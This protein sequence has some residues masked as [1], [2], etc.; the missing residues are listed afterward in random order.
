MP[1]AYVAS[2]PPTSW[3]EKAGSEWR[4]RTNKALILSGICRLHL[5]R[6]NSELHIRL[7]DKDLGPDDRLGEVIAPL[8]EELFDGTAR[9]FHITGA[10]KASGIVTV[11]LYSA[12][13]AFQAALTDMSAV[14]NGTHRTWS[15]DNV[16]GFM[17]FLLF[18]SAL[19]SLFWKGVAVISE[20][21]ELPR[22][23]E[24]STRV[25]LDY[26][27]D[28]LSLTTRPQNEA[29]YANSE[30]GGRTAAFPGKG[31]T[32]YLT[33]KDVSEKLKVV[34]KEQREGKIWRG[35]DLGNIRLNKVLYSDI[36]NSSI[37]L[38]VSPQDH[39]WIRPIVDEML[40][41]RGNWSVKGIRDSVR[42]FLASRRQLGNL[43]VQAHIKEWVATYLHRV[44]LHIEL[45]KEEAA[46]FVKIQ[47][48]ALKIV[49][50][51]QLVA[52]NWIVGKFLGVPAIL[53]W[54]KEWLEKYKLALEPKYP[55]LPERDLHLLASF[56]MDSL[57]FAG[58]LSVP[59]CISCA[60]GVVYSLHSPNSDIVLEHELIPSL[61]METLR[62][63]PP[64]V[65]FPYYDSPLQK[66]R[67]LLQLSC[68]ARDPAVWGENAN[69]FVLRPLSVYHKL[70]VSWA[71]GAVDGSMT[72]ACPARELSIK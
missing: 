55:D 24:G 7:L 71:D 30:D 61:I 14:R 52:N 20:W 67:T 39:E 56:V 64:V 16:S 49:V 66:K 11:V 62:Y 19:S 65:A 21:F 43:H 50:L 9:S 27:F 4:S 31:C 2:V 47:S 26:I 6:E 29:F 38:A 23:N 57:L 40:G 33:H 48:Q 54:K 5:L 45:S 10:P 46:E 37:G 41:A 58:G 72:R 68:A 28:M 17:S 59:L 69:S 12:N 13:E 15:V 60:L 35:N 51:P 25:S 34:G 1:T 3:E 32:A 22:Q 8:N 44:H 70:M 53:K 36:E 42:A 18:N 63:F